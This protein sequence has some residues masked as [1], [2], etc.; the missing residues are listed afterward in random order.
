MKTP[1]RLKTGIFLTLAAFFAGYLA[2]RH[3]D[4]V[5]S[6]ASI[7]NTV[8][9]A[10]P[11]HPLYNSDRA[12]TCPDCGM[13]LAP[14]SGRKAFAANAVPSGMARASAENEK[15]VKDLVCGMTVDPKSPTT[16]KTQYKGV[17]Y[18]FC[19]E[20]CKKSFVANPEKYIPKKPAV[21]KA[22]KVKDLVCG[23]TV[24]PNSPSVFKS[25]YKGQTYYFCS[26]MCKKSFEANPEK[27]V[28]KVAEP[29]SHGIH[30]TE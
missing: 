29:G 2:N 9:Y 19:S 7:E 11:M 28:H 26:E 21:A 20:S 18:Y 25:Q 17:T 27:Y 24:D 30:T 5:A 13:S 15:P 22:E 23:M 14:D 4:A 8:E 16:Q 1:A 3:N 12:S 10:R 6:A